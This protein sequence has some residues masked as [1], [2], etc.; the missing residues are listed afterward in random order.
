MSRCGKPNLAA[1][2]SFVNVFKNAV[3]S[4]LELELQTTLMLPKPKREL[5]N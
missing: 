3:L 1:R 4:N 2:T 5:T